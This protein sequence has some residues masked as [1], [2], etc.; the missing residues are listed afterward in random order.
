ML[1]SLP[2]RLDPVEHDEFDVVIRFFDSQFDERGC[3]SWNA[4][5]DIWH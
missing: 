5:L 2:E 1:V 4:V 3:G